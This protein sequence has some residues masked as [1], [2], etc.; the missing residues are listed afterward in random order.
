MRFGA[1]VRE[2]PLPV[3]GGQHATCLYYATRVHLITWQVEESLPEVCMCMFL[4]V[5][6]PACVDALLRCLFL[7][8]YF[9]RCMH[10]SKSAGNSRNEL[11][12]SDLHWLTWS[13]FSLDLNTGLKFVSLLEEPWR[14][15]NTFC[16]RRRL[17]NWVDDSWLCSGL[18]IQ[19]VKPPASASH[20]AYTK[21][22]SCLL[23]KSIS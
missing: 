22:C 10:K 16:A 13:L 21:I 23:K 17:K 1:H 3:I 9:I 15:F 11:H 19:F 4:C 6:V 12:Q 20:A 8:I 14:W 18:Q 7:F 2:L 5:S